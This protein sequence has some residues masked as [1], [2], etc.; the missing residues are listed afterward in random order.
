MLARVQHTPEATLLDG[1]MKKNLYYPNPS[2]CDDHAGPVLV[3]A[4]KIR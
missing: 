4:N 1:K 3:I 2:M